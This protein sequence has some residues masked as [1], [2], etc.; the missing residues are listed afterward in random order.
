MY[1]DESG[2]TTDPTQKY[3]VLSGIAVFERNTHCVSGRIILH[4][5]TLNFA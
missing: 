1:V 3:F 4:R 5:I 2:S